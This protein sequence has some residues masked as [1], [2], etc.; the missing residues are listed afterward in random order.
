MIFHDSVQSYSRPTTNLGVR[1]HLARRSALELPG[2]ALF[3]KTAGKIVLGVCAV[4][5]AMN[6]ILGAYVRH[7][8]SVVSIV[9]GQRHELMDRNITLRAKRA[10][11]LT[12]QAI[13]VAA[14]KALSLYTPEKGQRFVYSRD[15][16]R[17]E[18]L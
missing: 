2:G 11:L 17:F 18:S 7:L 8:D 4:T 16:G 9:E 1:Q 6:I 13:E 3:W 15:K 10:G 14:G 5:I 12:R